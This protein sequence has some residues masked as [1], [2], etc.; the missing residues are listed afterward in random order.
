MK[1]LSMFATP[2]RQRQTFLWFG[3]AMAL[4]LLPSC[5][6]TEDPS[7]KEPVPANQLSP[8]ARKTMERQ[9]QEAV[10]IRTLGKVKEENTLSPYR[11]VTSTERYAIFGSLVKA[12]SLSRSIHS[13]GVTLLC[14]K[15]EAF[16]ADSNWKTMLREENRE[17]LDNWVSRHVIPIVMSYGDFKTQVEHLDV[18][19]N[20]IKVETRGGITANG[21]RVRS[22]DVPTENG[23]IIG[24]DDLLLAPTD[25][26]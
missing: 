1:F 24:L 6:S 4:V 16:E 7:A 15:D 20:V 3:I 9:K 25:A 17:A 13:Q 26:L 2:Q 14:P 5:N 8:Q 18:N 22:G 12:S 19:G 23:T 21:A 11:Y 10:R